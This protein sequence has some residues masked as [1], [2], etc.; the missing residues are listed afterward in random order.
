M[1]RRPAGAGGSCVLGA[2]KKRVLLAAALLGA[3]AVLLAWCLRVPSNSA[4]TA[5]LKELPAVAKAVEP[6]CCAAGA[7]NAALQ[8]EAI[9]EA[10]G[11]DPIF[12]EFAAWTRT[13]LGAGAA[14]RAKLEAQ[15]ARLAARREEVL[16]RL[17]ESDP[18][19]AL[20]V[21]APRTS[22]KALPKSVTQQ[23]ERPFSER[24]G[25]E[26][27]IATAFS[28]GA[29]P[30]VQRFVTLQGQRYA[31]Y[32]YGRRLNQTTKYDIPM[33][34]IV[35][36]GKAVVHPSPARMIEPG[37]IPDPNAPVGN[38][39][40]LCPVSGLAASKRDA[41]DVGGTIYYLCHSGH[42]DGLTEQ[43][44]AAEGGTAPTGDGAIAQSAWTQ[45][46]KTILYINL[47]FS[48]T[49]LANTSLYH[50]QA[51][52]QNMADG[53]AAFVQENSYGTTTITNT[54][55]PLLILPQT[56][57]YYTTNGDYALQSD[58]WAVA[59]AAGYDKANYWS[60][61]VCWKG[62][63]G[64]YGGQGYV[65]ARGVWL[66]SATAGVA[67]HEFGHNFG[68]WHANFWT[69]TG[70]S[71]IGAGS[72]N[73]YGDSYDTM[74][75][76]N[77][78]GYHFNACHK[79]L[80]GWLPTAN[81][82][83]VTASGTY[84][85]TAFDQPVI[86]GT[87][88]YAL[89]INKDA[90]RDYWVDLRQKFTSN[91]FLMSGADLHWDPWASSAG[92]THLLDTTAGSSFGKTDSAIVIGRTFSDA[93]A[94]VYITPIGKGGTSPESL[95]V[96]V[97]KGSFPSNVAPT[98]SLSASATAVAT[99]TVVTFTATATD[100]NGDTLAYYWDFSDTSSSP[101]ND[102]TFG[103][104]SS[105]NTKKWSSAGKYVVYCQV[106]DMK[107]GTATD[108]VLVTVG[109]P[110]TFTI[111]GTVLDASSN[112]VAGARVY[113]SSSQIGYTDSDGQYTI[114][115]LSANSY[116]VSAVK[117][118]Y[119]MTAN[120]T[121]PVAV[122]PDATG[123]NFTA[124]PML[125]A[126]T[127]KVT[128]E[129]VAVSGATVSAGTRST[130]SDASGNF[131]LNLPNGSHTLS[132][133]KAGLTLVPNGWSNP[134]AV[135]DVAVSGKNFS[136]PLGSIAGT[137]T[138]NGA[139]VSGVTVSAGG[140]STT[141][142][143]SGTYTLP[144]V[145]FGTITLTATKAGYTFSPSSG[146]SNPFTFNANLTGRNFIR[147]LYTVSGQITGV[148]TSGTMATVHIGDGVH[149]TTAYV[150]GNGSNK[151]V[152][153]SLSVPDG[154]WSIYGDLAGYLITP[155]GFTNPIT[156]SGASQSGRDLI[157]ST[158]STHKISGRV[159]NG[160]DGIQ[161][162][163]VSDGTRS[164]KTD[165]IGN[166]AI[167]GVP[168]GSYTLTPSLSGY[169]FTPVTLAV[170]MAGADLTGKNF[171]GSN[172]N[173]PPTI[174]NIADQ[175]TSEDTAKS[176]IAFTVGDAETAA[177]S[178]AVS[179]SSGNTML[180]PNTNITF[181][182]SGANRTV[183][184]MPAANQNG[185][186]TITVTV[187]DGIQ[188]ASD[189]FVLTVTAV[190]DAPVANNQSVSTA[191]D[192]AKAITL[193]A[194]D[195]EGSAL[196]YSIV[197]NPANGT[198]SGTA[199]NVTYT[200]ASNY[201]GSDSFTFRANDGAL[202]SNTATVSITV[203]AVNDA[204]V[205]NNQN[206]TTA[207]DT[208]KAIT[209]TAS[210][211]EGSA[212]TYS[213]VANPT[214]GSLSGSA[215]N[216]S[217]TPALNFNGP[218]SFT[219]RVSDG[220]LNSNTATIS[221]TVTSSN[222]APVIDSAP[223]AT[224]N[225][226]VLPATSTVSVVASDPDGDALTYT[227]SKFS[228]TGTVGFSPNGT[229]LSES[230]SATFS[231]AGTYVLRVTVFD[232]SLSTTGDVTV[233]VTPPNQAPVANNQ[234][235]STAEDTA[236]AVTLTATDG[237]GD[238]LTY[239]IVANPV[240]GTV[241]LSGA[242]ATYT[243]ALN[244]NGPDSF[245]F[246]A[247]DGFQ[248]SN[249]ATV[250]ITVTAVNDAP[251]ANNQS[252]STGEDTAKA[253]TLAAS[254]VEGSALSY[255]IVANPTNG[256]LSGSAPN[257]TYTPASNYNGPDSFTFRANDGSLNSNT[258][259]VSIT[260]TAVNDA[261][262]ASN[263]SVSTAEDTAKAITLTAT[264]IEGSALTFTVVANPLHGTVGIS[265]T[266]AT[267]TPAA[268]YN[269]PDS[270][271]FRANDGSLNSNTATVSIT[272]TAVND[273]P[274]ATNQSVSTLEDTA[275][276]ITLTATDV[277]GSALTYAVVANPAHGTVSISGA[278]ATYTPVLNY[279]GPDS[280]TF[281]AND[282]ALNSNTATVS[283][284]VTAVNDAP[285]ANDQ[286][287]ST[288]KNAAKVV[289]LTGSDVEGSALTITILTTPAHGTVSLSGA[290]ATYTPALNYVGSDTFTFRCSDG[291]LN[292]NTATV[293]ISV[294][295]SNAAPVASNKNLSTAE[296][297]AK[298]ATLSATDLDGDPLTY[299][300][301]SGPSHGSLGG[302]APNLTYTPAANYN[303]PDSFTYKV[304]DGVLDSNTATFSITVTAVND[305]PAAAILT[306]APM[307][308]AKGKSA[309]LSG[310]GSDVED[311]ASVTYDW[312]W[313]DGTAHGS[314]PN[315]SHAWAT[316]GTYTVTLIVKDLNNMASDPVTMD[317]Q[318]TPMANESNLYLK[319]GK[320][321][322]N[323]KAH[324]LGS[325][326]DTFAVQGCLNP[327]GID[328]VLSNASFELSVN[329][330][331]LGV[332]PLDASGKGSAAFGGA[333]AK[334]SLKANTGSFS[335][336]VK[337]AD[338]TAAL[339]LANTNESGTTELAIDVTVFGAGLAT[340]TATGNA[341]FS[342]T[343]K[344][345]DATKGGFNFKTGALMDGV[346]FAAKTSVAEDKAGGHKVSV[347][348]VLSAPGSSALVPSGDV[349]L[350]IGTE[351]IT[352]PLANLASGGGVLVVAKGAHP[353]LDAFVIDTN[354][355]AFTI[356]TNVLSGTGVPPAGDSVTSHGLLLRIVIPTAGGAVT[357]ESTVEIL[358]KDSNST[359]WKR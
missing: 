186:A 317:V 335:Y 80:L 29:Q 287:V 308:V 118:G 327:A 289:T 128:D 112:P 305:K 218:D 89:K 246:R 22:R 108:T 183:T 194:S 296:D 284:S 52:I 347:K 23:M 87:T 139:G 329:G 50:S 98:V 51:T 135:A 271:T 86:S 267:Y 15:G 210:D 300:I 115:N 56:L 147:P 142:S 302:A 242:T 152:N 325:D 177:G 203:T 339:G 199:P 101:T 233:V 144:H 134:V 277:E 307:A 301:V 190:N 11:V 256:T 198:L 230:S 253:I 131:T 322:I 294:L 206:V 309:A 84:R 319:K 311:G 54:I 141:T 297:T 229:A 66:K 259:T 132:A 254:D 105:T 33:H 282:G 126:V 304:N 39:D 343:T 8:D 201:S 321:A 191:E 171:T 97:N 200:P 4:P 62:G 178:L 160:V 91:K 90:D 85:V 175:T 276:A 24:G 283:I 32:T 104:N 55:T 180:V 100:A 121:N 82:T 358:R 71:I 359:K 44:I 291:S 75:S 344:A 102:P 232:G 326:A 332:I 123:N 204:P 155:N 220:S 192:T 49:D 240:H 9:P 61:A 357:F 217:Y 140:V 161:G 258:A 31:A 285:V 227:W 28:E 146:W 273:A 1:S 341:V 16:A 164:A 324:N 337:G 149:S 79:N 268:N 336:A 38:P 48:D 167:V 148:P 76:A 173:T 236:K 19:S 127:G 12:G 99:N 69:A 92:G 34:G 116:T 103:V 202:N 106:T 197:T 114:T 352:I 153:Y 214:H 2:R 270:F 43:Q 107:G 26:V 288:L 193:T 17:I 165:S 292:S 275:K 5:E 251:V 209:L 13:Y 330:I 349:G 265:G 315:P 93:A 184:V 247:N 120:F 174:S 73:E 249:T 136:T 286:S 172:G 110:T 222:D 14:E 355:K 72:N 122:G 182:G 328:A 238:P 3:G 250:T 130:T 278:T 138:D 346:F 163:T 225:P 57:S 20:R 340:E 216:V 10:R 25:Y 179:G 228:G 42:I 162:V 281:R 96:V 27:V 59:K 211:I 323:W 241:S 111:S 221:I 150:S 30:K 338:L 314:G 350:V 215:P 67:V 351:S 168:D 231:T 143:G 156:I 318:V 145:P 264:D 18:E 248:N 234:S 188:S 237:D 235:V 310:L 37:E 185:T 213:I 117:Y 74:G 280:F 316:L 64:G 320:F 70:D 333:S 196:T 313:G 158:S 252:V 299:S 239:A 46:A 306:A 133:A 272:V 21:A 176:N 261:P 77:A 53:C 334:V 124:G 63:P 293:S 170:T 354:K 47:A 312:N 83:T 223:W 94:G 36:G 189:S 88:S 35:L 290:N 166:Y 78:G 262:V 7:S 274:V 269:G 295:P 60:E 348:G 219:F 119:T 356:A 224:P 208:A 195:V 159:T 125:Y 109:S 345:D 113:V 342:Y 226:V 244:Y 257:V 181:G 95:D 187:S 298:A 205:A 137:V 212:L 6:S 81:V 45:G 41:V 331:S 245:T 207:E 154:Q 40:L 169:S 58:G 266:T 279:N 263:Q 243:P 303:G 353:A 68:L 151:K 129:G 255:A 260:V 65:G 157:G